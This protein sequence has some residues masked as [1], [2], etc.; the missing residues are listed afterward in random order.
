MRRLLHWSRKEGDAGSGRDRERDRERDCE[1]DH[2]SLGGR[3][4]ENSGGK[5]TRNGGNIGGEDDSNI[6]VADSQELE[7]VDESV[8]LGPIFKK[9]AGSGFNFDNDPTLNLNPSIL[10]NRVKDD[11]NVDL[12]SHKAD[13]DSVYTE[14]AT[15]IFSSRPSYSTKQS[16]Y[17]SGKSTRKQSTYREYGQP[18]Q[19]FDIQE[20]TYTQEDDLLIEDILKSKITNLFQDLQYIMNQFKNN[21]INL[22]KAIINCIDFFKTFLNFINKKSSNYL[23]SWPII[24]CLNNENLRKIMRIYLHFYD[25]LLIDD[26]YIKLKL[27]LSRNFNDFISSLKP[28]NGINSSTFLSNNLSIKPTNFAIDCNRLPNQ[29]KLANIIDKL[30]KSSSLLI[31]P[32]NGSFVA[33]ITR[34]ISSSFKIL[35][36][37]CG[38]PNPSDFHSKSIMNIAEL[39]DDIHVILVKN[40]IE[41]ASLHPP[42]NPIE[43][44]NH[45]K[46]QPNKN[47]FV[48][49]PSSSKFKM[50]FRNPT[51]INSPP[52]SISISVETSSRTSGTLGGY[53]YP[54]ID[55]SNPNLSEATLSSAKSKFALTCGHVCLDS[56]KPP[57]SEAKYP[58]VSLPS[59]VLISLYKQ[60]LVTQYNKATNIDQ[61]AKV[62]YGSVIKQLD[63][64]FPPKRVKVMKPREVF[65]IRNLPINRFGQIVWGERTM[66]SVKDKKTNQVIGKRLSDI[67]II[68]VNKKLSCQ[69]FLGDD[70]AFNEFDPGLMFENLYVRRVVNFTRKSPA[71]IDLNINEVDSELEE[72]AEPNNHN[73][74]PVFKYGSTTRFTKGNLNGIRLV[75]WLDGAIHSS[76]FVVNSVESNTAFAAGGDSGAWILT[77]LEDLDDRKKGLGVVGMLHSF[78]G[79]HKQFGLFSPMCEILERLEE[80][81]KLKWGVVGVP[82]KD[83]RNDLSD[84]SS[85]VDSNLESDSE[86]DSDSMDS[87][88]PPEID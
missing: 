49:S 10:T 45:T 27:M 53:V 64:I 30:S 47:H 7:S 26:V 14:N 38:F 67:A 51:D 40:Q 77:K 82:E 63:L 76:E 83:D 16:S 23:G 50:P 55:K 12:G 46:L 79:E 15:T 19:I 75:Y 74:L 2:E 68:K 60:A 22:S 62:A 59:S 24:N 29:E 54:I 52:M 28:P 72:E 33:P 69:N 86:S 3:D 57:T 44:T 18:L 4:Q 80:T 48:N 31:S 9:K 65:E 21:Q 17:D 8:D 42:L 84:V 61:E 36:L 25:N 66:N 41:L 58:H 37:Y 70:I 32:Q 1:R 71:H 85:A 39:Y 43:P 56:S 87:T 6:S 13:A 5:D 81:T 78:D 35:C 20:D 88:L 34:G 73:G 11:E